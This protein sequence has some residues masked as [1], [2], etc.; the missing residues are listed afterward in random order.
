MNIKTCKVVVKML[1]MCHLLL[2]KVLDEGDIMAV[3][4]YETFEND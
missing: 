4:S 2:G 3:S 1:Y